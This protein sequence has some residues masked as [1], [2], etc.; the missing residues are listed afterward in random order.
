MGAQEGTPRVGRSA[1]H[2]KNPHEPAPD[3][4]GLSLRRIWS[5]WA[6]GRNELMKAKHL[7]TACIAAVA[8]AACNATPQD[9][10]TNP[11]QDYLS[12]YGNNDQSVLGEGGLSLNLFG[13]KNQE[14]GGPAGIGVN[15]YLW[16]ASLDT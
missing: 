16:R 5:G 14:G 12:K 4:G 15:T 13:K 3:V 7:V 2:G 10:Y 11:R 1:S 9:P 6:I 8:L